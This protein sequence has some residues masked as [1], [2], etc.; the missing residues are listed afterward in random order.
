[1]WIRNSLKLL[2]IAI[3][4]IAI[5]LG[6][7]FAAYVAKGH[8]YSSA[9]L[10][11]PDWLLIIGIDSRNE[12]DRGLP[13]ALMLK[14]LTTGK[15]QSISRTWK[16][17]LLEPSRSLVERYLAI[18]DCEPFCNVQGVYAYSAQSGDIRTDA[19]QGVENLRNLIEKEYKLTSVAVVAFDLQWAKSFLGHIGGVQVNVRD[20]IRKGGRLVDGRLQ[21]F[22]GTILTGTQKLNGDDLF[23]YSRSRYGSDNPARMGR[24]EEVFRELLSQKT[25]A[26]LIAAGL[27]AS[28]MLITDLDLSELANVLRVLK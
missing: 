8:E 15:I 5:L 19:I 9:R 13:D 4:L 25:K 14:D 26:E 6:A 11:Q 24:Q 12:S 3:L 16:K 27:Q 1:M 20:V 7:L 10:R 21:K 17:S 28:G 18:T 22:N 2:T 23:W